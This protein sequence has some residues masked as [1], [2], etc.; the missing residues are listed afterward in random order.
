MGFFSKTTDKNKWKEKYLK[1]LDEHD[2]AE[3]AYKK[4][5]R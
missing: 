2:Q 5:G 3:S 1:L 4:L